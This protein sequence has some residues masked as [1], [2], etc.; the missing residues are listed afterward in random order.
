MGKEKST[1][2]A[3]KINS[4]V[5]DI[6]QGEVFGGH[7]ERWRGLCSGFSLFFYIKARRELTFL[8]I[9]CERDLYSSR[10]PRPPLKDREEKR[11]RKRA[12][13]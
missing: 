12:E 6:F 5:P 4:L 3:Y 1:S 9:F 2:V 10:P 8:S 7:D 11:E 13:K